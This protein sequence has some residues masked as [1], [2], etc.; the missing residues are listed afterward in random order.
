M[1]SKP[2]GWR[3]RAPTDSA[4]LFIIRFDGAIGCGEQGALLQECL[5]PP[6]MVRDSMVARGCRLQPKLA[7][8]FWARLSNLRPI[9]G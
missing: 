5:P 7:T 4:P 1:A 3:P 8:D 6:R 2:E 9:S